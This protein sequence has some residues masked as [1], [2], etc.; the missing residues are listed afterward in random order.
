MDESLDKFPASAVGQDFF[1]KNS[2]LLPVQKGQTVYIPSGY[3]SSITCFML[4]E[5]NAPGPNEFISQLPLAGKF[6][7]MYAR[8]HM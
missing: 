8:R 2:L 7:K 6:A 5:R 4:L 3:I 1:G